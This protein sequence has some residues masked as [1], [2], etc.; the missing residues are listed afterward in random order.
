MFDYLEFENLKHAFIVFF[1][2]KFEHP[3][4]LTKYICSKFL[5]LLFTFYLSPCTSYISSNVFYHS[6]FHLSDEIYVTSL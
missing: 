2:I 6:L 5:Q 3:V 1:G 4:L